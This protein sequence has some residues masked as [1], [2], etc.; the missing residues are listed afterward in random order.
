MKTYFIKHKKFLVFFAGLLCLLIVSAPLYRI[1]IPDLVGSIYRGE[2]GSL[3]NSLIKDQSRRPLDIYLTYADS[4]FYQFQGYLIS[5]LF[6]ST[7]YFLFILLV[8]IKNK[9]VQN[10]GILLLVLITIFGLS[11]L[12]LRYLMPVG[13]GEISF[14]NYQ[15]SSNPD[16]IIEPR[17]NTGEFNSD[18]FRDKLYPREKPAGV[19][20]IIV[21]GDSLAYGL[22]VPAANT[23]AKRL[24]AMLNKDS[25]KDQRYEVIN[26]GVPGYR[27][28]QIIARL[29]DRG[30]TFDP[31]MIIYGYWLDD[32]S[33]SGLVPFY[34]DQANQDVSE[35]I[36]RGMS[37]NPAERTIKKILLQSQI[38]RRFIL[39]MRG[40]YRERKYGDD[41]D[42][43]IFSTEGRMKNLPPEIETISREF[44]AA[45]NR[46]KYSDLP[47][48][49]PYYA[50]Y[51]DYEDFIAWNDGFRRLSQI[52]RDRS[53]R[54]LLLM[55]PVIYDYPG[56]DY[57]WEGLHSFIGSIARYYSIPSID[58]TDEFS[59]YEAYQLRAGD[60]EHPNELG[61][62]L[63][64]DKLYE[65]IVNNENQSLFPIPQSPFPES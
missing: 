6:L 42:G 43:N 46:G 26:M 38:V 27:T 4:I 30:I 53:I 19:Y 35:L 20:R 64:A 5:L 45:F 62:K 56:G 15:P 32:I 8:L 41:P 23:Y 3:L 22:R 59:E 40:I 12:L 29:E 49:D 36:N 61:H 54:P 1:F 52:C 44:I 51:A 21:I 13:I 37:Q 31:D 63:I 33:Y 57:A 9:I 10:I 28:I 60:H 47:G 39:L 17:P 48:S 18:G 50:R 65:Y 55:T 2:A 34:F 24:E 7:L 14:A 11:E 25:G 58:L 16:I